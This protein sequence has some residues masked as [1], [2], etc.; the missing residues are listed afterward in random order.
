[1][2]LDKLFEQFVLEKQY[3]QNCAPKT[4]IHYRSSF[5]T[6]RRF[7]QADEVTDSTINQFVIEARR[8]GMSVGC[9]NSY[10][11]GFNS[12]LDWL[13]EQE[14]TPKHLKVKQLKQEKKIG[15]SFSHEELIRM[16]TYKPSTRPAPEVSLA[17]EC[18]LGYKPHPNSE[19][20][21]T[22]WQTTI[23]KLLTFR[24]RRTRIAAP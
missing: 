1:M 7:V 21:F 10:V 8:A 22:Q 4:I 17:F 15:R 18:Q 5:K 16:I 23:T 20:S 2:T 11:R 19:R 14:I 3:V 9:L 6:Y 24:S 13:F 12:F